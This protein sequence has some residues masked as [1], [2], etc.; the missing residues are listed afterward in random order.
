M[1]SLIEHGLIQKRDLINQ[2][3][4]LREREPDF[5]TERWSKT[6]VQA[7]T[8]YTKPLLELDPDDVEDEL[9]AIISVLM[10]LPTR[11]ESEMVMECVSTLSAARELILPKP[12]SAFGAL[13]NA[14][15]QLGRESV[16]LW[17]NEM[18]T[19]CELAQTYKEWRALGVVS[20]WKHGAV[21]FRQVAIKHLKS[22][23]W[24]QIKLVMGLADTTHENQWKANL[25]NIW[26][27][28]ILNKPDP[29][30]WTLGGFSGFGGPFTKKPSLYH[31]GESI[32]VG[33]DEQWFVVHADCFGASLV[34]ER[35]VLQFNHVQDEIKRERVLQ[36]YP[37][38]GGVE[39]ALCHEGM[40]VMTYELSL[41]IKV[42]PWED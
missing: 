38:E 5:N 9:W 29:K 36:K 35:A 20:A 2:R 18:K 16:K 25:D 22:L 41:K 13:I 37:N 23:P 15:C 19:S 34:P 32:W 4:R 26:W 42:L 11:I 28:P 6:L 27:N 14:T 3:I 24:S 10:E 30:T 39:S 31:D 40:L 17:L 1:N 8:I 21:Q 33:H 12:G 7:L